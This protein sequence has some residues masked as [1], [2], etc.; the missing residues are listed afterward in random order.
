ME[1]LSILSNSDGLTDY[2]RTAVVSWHG[3]NKGSPLFFNVFTFWKNDG[4]YIFGQSTYIISTAGEM[5]I[6]LASGYRW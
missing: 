6:S 4:L 1:T 3:L 2:C 5:K